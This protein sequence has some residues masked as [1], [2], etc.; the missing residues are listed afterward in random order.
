MVQ[1]LVSSPFKNLLLLAGSLV[2]TG[3]GCLM[4]HDSRGIA[5]WFVTG[6]FGVCSVVFA[7]SLLPGASEL[8]LF[9]EGFVVRS[10][11]RKWPLIRWEAVGEF[12]AVRIP[13]SILKTVAFD[14]SDAPA[15]RLT[16]M[17][18]RLTG[19]SHC[20]PDTY[21]MPAE[22][23]ADFLNEWRERATG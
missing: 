7:I 14:T 10:L 15:R 9:R 20:L 2:F 12:R 11:F 4:I 18:R 21:G 5:A 8:A 6:F 17:S 1:R 3:I 23:L 16:T 22:E 13:G 19:V